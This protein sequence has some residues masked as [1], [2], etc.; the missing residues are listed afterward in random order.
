ME[1]IRIDEEA[2]ALLRQ[3]VERQAYRE[4]MAAN[5]R[6]HGLRFLPDLDEKIECTAEVDFCLRAV[7]ELEQIYRALD[8]EDLYQASRARMARI[9]YP[10]SRLELAVC[11]ALIERAE[12]IAAAAYLDCTC[13]P[14]A[15][16]ARTL[17]EAKHSVTLREEQVFI[18]FCSDPSQAPRARQFFARWLRVALV[19]LGRPG[20]RGDTRA[21]ALGLRDKHCAAVMREFLMEVDPLRRQCGLRFPSFHDLQVELPAELRSEFETGDQTY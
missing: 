17:V 1:R 13:K 15:A 2:R 21:V 10:Q 4:L 12:R 16:V 20:T 14:F 19:A 7:H 3:I 8:G 11:L 5:I 9:P 18:D 6:G